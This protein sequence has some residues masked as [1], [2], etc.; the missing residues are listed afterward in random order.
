MTYPAIDSDTLAAYELDEQTDAGL[1]AP[2]PGFLCPII[3]GYDVGDAP[4]FTPKFH[5]PPH[6]GGWLGFKELVGGSTTAFL[7]DTAPNSVSTYGIGLPGLFSPPRC[8]GFFQGTAS[9]N[10]DYIV[11]NGPV[12]G[13]KT[14]S[15]WIQPFQGLGAAQEI[16]HK[17]YTND[18]PTDGVVSGTF[19]SPFYGAMQFFVTSGSDGSWG[20]SIN[21]GGTL[22][23]V[24]ITGNSS[25]HVRLRYNIWNHVGAT[26]D[27]AHFNVYCN[28]QLAASIALAGAIDYGAGPW[29]MGALRD[30]SISQLNAMAE[31]VRWEGVAKGLDYFF[32][33]YTNAS[34]GGAGG[35][36]VIQF[37]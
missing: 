9:A 25:E 11:L 27:G 16:L 22:H 15:L 19:A 26:Y 31:R 30:G 32:D 5:S 33:C 21:I 13:L 2:A 6:F 8:V 35:I 12:A 1:L 23:T 28:G 14:T 20:V 37:P 17:E 18:A 36:P 29:V 4:F 7:Y 10:R 3:D 24:T 34:G